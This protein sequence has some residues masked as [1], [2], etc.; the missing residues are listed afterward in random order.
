MSTNN[1]KLLRDERGLSQR[2][3]GEKLHVSPS[4]LSMVE[5]GRLKPWPRLKRKL[6]RIFKLSEGDIFP[7]QKGVA[8]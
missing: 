6:A 2:E 4:L 7:E 3:L 1:L 8:R 5:T